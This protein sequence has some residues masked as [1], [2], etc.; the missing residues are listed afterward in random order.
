MYR[1]KSFDEAL[2]KKLKKPR[3]AREFLLASME[4]NDGMDLFEALKFTISCM[5][6]KEF[7]EASGILP[8]N[9]SRA[10]SQ[11]SA[12]KV[13]TLNKFLAPFKLRV[14]IDVEKV[15]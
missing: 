1:T 9:I 2:S 11:D 8:P 13:E 5:G 14:K 12:P 3:Y 15:A 7:S 6:T 4:G 10:L